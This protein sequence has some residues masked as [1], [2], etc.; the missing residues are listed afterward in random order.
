MPIHINPPP[1][2][3]Q[4]LDPSTH[5]PIRTAYKAGESLRSLAKRFGVSHTR[6]SHIINPAQYARNNKLRDQYRK[7]GRYK[8]KK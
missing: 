3:R 6:I 8:T 7:E 4:K 5:E 1:D 2:S